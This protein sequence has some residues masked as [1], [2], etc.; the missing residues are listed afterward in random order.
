MSA[1]DTAETAADK[2]ASASSAAD[3]LLL[4]ELTAGL[5]SSIRPAL[6]ADVDPLA[7]LGA[8]AEL[9]DGRAQD[10]RYLHLGDADAFADRLLGE[11]LS[12]AEVQY[13][14]V[15]LLQHAR[16]G[17]QVDTS[18]DPVEALCVHADEFAEG[19]HRSVACSVRRLEREGLSGVACLQGVD[20]VCVASIQSF[21]DLAD[22]GLARK[23]TLEPAVCVVRVSSRRSRGGRTLHVRSRKWRLISPTIVGTA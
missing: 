1:S 21:G 7:L 19:A 22:R 10:A 2:P 16:E 8:V 4:D 11:V 3:A 13:E 17:T 6:F 5:D 20:D 12:E 18:V 23:L 9:S 15:A 14:T